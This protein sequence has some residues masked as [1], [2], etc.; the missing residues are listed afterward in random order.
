MPRIFA[1]LMVSLFAS[2]GQGVEI[3]V[4]EPKSAAKNGFPPTVHGE[5]LVEARD[6][7]VMLQGDDGRIWTFQPEQIQQRSNDGIPLAPIDESEISRRLLKEL[8]SGFQIHR[9]SN[10]VI[11]HNTNGQY[12]RQVGTLFEQ[13]NR[14][15]FTFWKNQK[16]KL[17]RPRF[18]LVGLVFANRRDFLEYAQPDIGDMAKS[19]IGYY[20]LE[21][22]RMVTFR[23]PNLERN[24]ATVIHEAT[25][26]IAYNCGLQQRFADNPM[27]VSEGLATFFEAPDFTNPRGWRNIG[28]VN[29]VNLGRWRRYMR[30]RPQNSLTTLIADDKRFRG[31]AATETAYA[32]CWALTYFLLKTR[33]DEYV[34]YLQELSEGKPLVALSGKERV[35]MF[36]RIFGSTIEQIDQ[37]LVRFIGRIQ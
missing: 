16:W 22:N 36:E 4:V 18:P 27:W 24:V 31:S 3:V 21:S 6:G 7:G 10:Y 35:A 8:P 32:E 26:Q 14:G 15:F 13:L 19:V 2:A 9:T 17:E 33:R 25:H 28:R 29:E 23:V 34:G 20:H 5:I 1:L 30:S 37:E 11:A 12:V